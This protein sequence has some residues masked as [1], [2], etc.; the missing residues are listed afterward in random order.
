[1]PANDPMRNALGVS[2][3]ISSFGEDGDV[4]VDVDDGGFVV[5]VVAEG[6]GFGLGW[7]WLHRVDFRREACFRE[8]GIVLRS[9]G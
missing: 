1:M 7:L 3:V 6:G 5:A 8:F 4:D 9:F 2:L